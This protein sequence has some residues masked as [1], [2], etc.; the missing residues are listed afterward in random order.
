MY[1]MNLN[2]KLNLTNVNNWHKSQ[3]KHKS[4][5]MIYSGVSKYVHKISVM[6]M[7]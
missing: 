4:S 7:T 2:F 3:K 6:H 5:Y 1:A